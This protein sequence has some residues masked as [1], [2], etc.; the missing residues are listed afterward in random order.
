MESENPL[1]TELNALIIE[2]WSFKDTEFDRWLGWFFNQRYSEN[3][4]LI[5]P[6]TDIRIEK[7]DD[8]NIT[9]WVMLGVNMALLIWQVSS[10]SFWSI[11]VPFEWWGL[12]LTNM[13]LVFCFWAWYKNYD[14]I[15]F[16][17]IGY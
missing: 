10:D 4:M 13:S 17:D 14:G 8:H 9:R 15:M 1:T 5:D 2:L 12:N 16:Y 11:A 3:D 7:L 6:N